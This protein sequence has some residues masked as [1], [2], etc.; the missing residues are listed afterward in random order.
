MFCFLILF[1]GGFEAESTTA[2]RKQSLTIDF[3]CDFGLW[4]SK[5]VFAEGGEIPNV[6]HIDLN[7]VKIQ[8]LILNLNF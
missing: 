2:N 8:I 1:T 5:S 6:R 7:F 4:Q 3:F